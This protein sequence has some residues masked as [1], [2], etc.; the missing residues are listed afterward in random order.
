M[1]LVIGAAAAALLLVAP[2]AAQTPPAGPPAA[3]PVSSNCG[4]FGPAPTLPDGAAADREQIAA[5]NTLY[6]SW[7]QERLAKLRLCRAEIEALRAQ[8]A[9]LEQAYTASNTELNGVV[10]AWTVEVAEFNARP[11]SSRNRRDSRSI[12]RN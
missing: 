12:N 3:P 5:G 10:A 9:P 11:A 2:V 4:N 7:G 8:L 1:K 6:D